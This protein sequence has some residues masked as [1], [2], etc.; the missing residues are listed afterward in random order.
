M[1]WLGT[2][3]IETTAGT[4]KVCD[5][6]WCKYW[7]NNNT[8]Y[9]ITGIEATWLCGSSA[10]SGLELELYH[11]K[12]TGWTYT[13]SGATPPSTTGLQLSD[14]VSTD[15]EQTAGS[16]YAWKRSG[17]SIAVDADGIEGTI[18]RITTTQNN[19][20]DLG[21]FTITKTN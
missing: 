2:V 3:A 6:G 14:A 18:F 4:A 15:N 16:S 9:T 8:D 1:K 13:G 21:N 20:V 12:A 11:H 7:D 5:Y 17:L 19:A 10:E